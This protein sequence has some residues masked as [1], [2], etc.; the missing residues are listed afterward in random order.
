MD[1]ALIAGAKS[2]PIDLDQDLPRPGFLFHGNLLQWRSSLSTGAFFDGRSLFSWKIAHVDVFIQCLRTSDR[3][4]TARRRGMGFSAIVHPSARGV[5]P[6]RTPQ[7][8][9]LAT[10]SKRVGGQCSIRSSLFEGKSAW[11]G[12]LHGTRHTWLAGFELQLLIGRLT[13]RGSR[14]IVYQNSL[15]LT[16]THPW[17]VLCACARISGSWVCGPNILLTSNPERTKIQSITH[18]RPSVSCSIHVEM[19]CNLTRV[20]KAPQNNQPGIQA[21]WDN[22]ILVMLSQFGWQ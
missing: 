11:T 1:Q 13:T 14:L 8:N 20:A 17:R 15:A 21:Q 22:A 6:P 7:D 3:K 4:R 9:G 10:S 5:T 16:L 19:L 12:L 18:N 2:S